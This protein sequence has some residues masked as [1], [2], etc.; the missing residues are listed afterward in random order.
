[1]NAKILWLGGLVGV[2]TCAIGLRADEPHDPYGVPGSVP[3]AGPTGEQHGGGF[4][5]DGLDHADAT[6]DSYILHPAGACCSP[7]CGRPI[8][9]EAYL[10]AG[11]S[12]NIG[13]SNLKGGLETGIDFGGGFRVLFFDHAANKAWAIDLGVSD[14]VNSTR[15][16]PSYTLI[17]VVNRP[18]GTVLPRVDVTPEGLNRTYFNYGFGRERYLW[19]SQQHEAPLNWRVGA[20]IGGR[21]GTAKMIFDQLNHRTGILEGV[22]TAIHTDVVI[23]W[24][25]YTLSAGVRL[26]WDY[27]WDHILQGQNNTDLSGF[28]LL[29]TGG[30]TF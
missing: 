30:I 26:E 1:M 8:V 4:A 25:C 2:L 22:Y 13:G 18:S 7:L 21:W 6:L 19:G 16:A 29:L 20:D 5:P 23:P 10:R 11:P 12:F 9:S 27:T 14:I 28:N 15:A 17:N 24:R 3:P